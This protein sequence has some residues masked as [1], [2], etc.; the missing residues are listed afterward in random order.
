MAINFLLC[1]SFQYL[2]S[3]WWAF[4]YRK[5]RL[6]RKVN[7][8]ME[9]ITVLVLFVG[10]LVWTVDWTVTFG[11]VYDTTISERCR[12]P[13]VTC[14]MRKRVQM[15]ERSIGKRVRSVRKTAK[16]RPRMSKLVLSW[17]CNWVF[18]FEVLILHT[19]YILTYTL[20]EG[21]SPRTRFYFDAL[22]Q[23]MVRR[24]C[25]TYGFY[26]T[27]YNIDCEDVRN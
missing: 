12:L 10:M 11:A 20:L 22:F 3:R 21:G 7:S 19:K 2:Y 4:V 27:D 23:W 16:Y 25:T 8:E 1:T 26:S 14:V 6:R 15:R 17:K 18:Y 9:N 24:A 5:L 13:I